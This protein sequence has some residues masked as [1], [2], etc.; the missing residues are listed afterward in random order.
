V[1]ELTGTHQLIEPFDNLP[2]SEL[3]EMATAITERKGSRSGLPRLV[4]SFRRSYT[5]RDGCAN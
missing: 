2:I 3:N 4:I 5:S 1:S